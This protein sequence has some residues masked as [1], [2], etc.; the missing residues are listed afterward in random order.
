METTILIMSKRWRFMRVSNLYTPGRALPAGRPQAAPWVRASSHAAETQTL[1]TR[2]APFRSTPNKCTRSSLCAAHIGTVRMMRSRNPYYG[3][4]RLKRF[5]SDSKLPINLTSG[6]ICLPSN[7]RTDGK[8]ED[9][10]FVVVPGDE[11]FRA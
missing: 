3:T 4:I 11:P 8:A 10:V 5:K 9:A 2:P 7:H 1:R 6:I